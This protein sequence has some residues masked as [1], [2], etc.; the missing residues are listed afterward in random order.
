MNEQIEQLKSD[1]AALEAAKEAMQ[2]FETKIAELE[3]QAD[4]PFKE[5]KQFIEY[6]GRDEFLLYNP[7]G[8][9][10]QVA[11]YV[12]HLEI[13]LEERTCNAAHMDN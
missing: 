3:R 13:Q 11:L 1:K 7:G 10:Q 5:A 12:R 6:W 8:I 4:D 9:L 2:K